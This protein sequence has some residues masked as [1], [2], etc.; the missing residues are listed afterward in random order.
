MVHPVLFDQISSAPNRDSPS[1]RRL[2]HSISV[3]KLSWPDAYQMFSHFRFGPFIVRS[4][5]VVRCSSDRSVEDIEV[6]HEVFV[7]E[8]GDV[9]HGVDGFCSPLEVINGRKG[10]YETP[11]IRIDT[12]DPFAGE[13]SINCLI[14]RLEAT[15]RTSS[16]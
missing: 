8:L 3:A 11:G 15:K 12:R 4:A 13:N 5:G 1:G 9:R 6:R 10:A 16:G 14:P 2:R 7:A